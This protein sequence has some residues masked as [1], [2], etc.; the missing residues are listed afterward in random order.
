M[1]QL[2]MSCGHWDRNLIF[3]DRIDLYM[4]DENMDNDY[5]SSVCCK[6]LNMVDEVLLV[7]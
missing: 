6:R 7:R 4:F 3:L 2:E 1:G 5:M